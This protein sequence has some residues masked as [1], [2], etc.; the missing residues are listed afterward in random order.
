MEEAEILA[1]LKAYVRAHGADAEA[2][3]GSSMRTAAQAQVD[4]PRLDTTV[5]NVWAA[6]ERVAQLNPR[7]PGLLNQAVQT[8]KK[9]M[10]RSLGWYTRSLQEFNSQVAYALQEE[11]LA[12]RSLDA[13]VKSLERT[14]S[15][16]RSE[17]AITVRPQPQDASPEAETYVREQR[18]RYVEWFDGASEV[19]DLN[20]GRGEFLQ[21]LR[22]HGIS[23]YGVSPARSTG[24]SGR[25]KGL[26]IVV[27][28]IL[29]HLK[30][31]AERSLGG[32]FSAGYIE[33]LPTQLQA[34]FLRILS[35]KLRPGA[36]LVI[37]T[38]SPGT[39]FSSPENSGTIPPDLLE[40]LL[41]VHGFRDIRIFS[42][43]TIECQLTS[44]T[45][46]ANNGS[47][48]TGLLQADR[49]YNPTGI[50]GV[51]ACRS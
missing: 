1:K 20:C 12:L 13:S 33:H 28:D 29:E 48:P 39:D 5:A 40:S 31:V 26:K 11:A 8:V 24:D 4:I 10:K 51:V 21:L 50:Y 23:A 14:I 42:L 32:A 45:N 9:T 7:N 49:R 18:R 22:E 19:V 16:L 34:E 2:G 25:R 35:G 38:V 36:V 37:E 15:G 17:A 46:R 6:K 41:E 3:D 47:R 43:A 30:E 27:A 44:E